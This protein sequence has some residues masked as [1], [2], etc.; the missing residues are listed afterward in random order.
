MKIKNEI[1]KIK[2]NSKY[3]NFFTESKS[4]LDFHVDNYELVKHINYQD[5]G[6]IVNQIETCPSLTH[7]SLPSE[8]ISN[9][10]RNILISNSNSRKSKTSHVE[11][12]K[13][14]I[15][16]TEIESKLDS[17]RIRHSSR[18]DPELT[19]QNAKIKIKKEQIYSLLN[20]KSKCRN[21]NKISSLENSKINKCNLNFKI[22][23]ALRNLKNKINK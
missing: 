3:S 18:E 1:S 22:S 13:I 14:F 4:S 11:S 6:V 15:P 10:K 21:G 9:L 2:S 23:L 19:K 17:L 12:S 16:L 20:E 8:R 7:G 5:K